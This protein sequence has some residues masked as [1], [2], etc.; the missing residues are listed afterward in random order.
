M[1]EVDVRRTLFVFNLLY[2]RRRKG[3]G[4]EGETGER[5]EF[6]NQEVRE[7]FI[8]NQQVT[9]RERE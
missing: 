4:V 6:D 2:Y 9:K 3:G 1:N 5:E 7:N 8:D